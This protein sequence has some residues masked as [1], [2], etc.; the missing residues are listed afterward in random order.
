LENVA[1]VHK[2]VIS[3]RQKSAELTALLAMRALKFSAARIASNL[4]EVSA[5]LQPLLEALT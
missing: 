1:A 5:I 2:S 3:L 4:N